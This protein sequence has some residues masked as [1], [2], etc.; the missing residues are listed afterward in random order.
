MYDGHR[1]GGRVGYVLELNRVEGCDEPGG[2]A[3]KAMRVGEIRQVGC[4]DR[5]TEL[6]LGERAR[7]PRLR[8]PLCPLPAA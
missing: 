2:R 3:R 7:E 8:G 5:T 1:V 4:L 6:I